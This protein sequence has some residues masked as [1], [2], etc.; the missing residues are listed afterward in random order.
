MKHKDVISLVD[1]ATRFSKAKGMNKTGFKWMRM[2]PGRSAN[3]GKNVGNSLAVLKAVRSFNEANKK[4]IKVFKA[5]G[6][7]GTPR[8]AMVIDKSEVLRLKG[9]ILRG[10]GK[11]TKP[12]AKAT[13]FKI[14]G[15]VD[16]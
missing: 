4:P 6:Y 15:E 3:K 7:D 11:K 10:G 13:A 14:I 2:A 8:L 5:R 9:F 16:V 1:L 12:A